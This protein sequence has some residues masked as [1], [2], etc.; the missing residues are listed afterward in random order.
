LIAGAATHT[1]AS[2]SSLLATSCS[3]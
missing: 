2:P 3:P 1:Y